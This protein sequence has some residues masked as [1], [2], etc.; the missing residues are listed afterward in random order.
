VQ[1][2]VGKE[3]IGW[4]TVPDQAWTLLKREEQRRNYAD[5]SVFLD[6]YRARIELVC[7]LPRTR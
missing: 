4:A 6:H 3:R 2:M 7:F 1:V 5:G